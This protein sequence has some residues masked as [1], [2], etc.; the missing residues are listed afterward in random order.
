MKD[1]ETPFLRAEFVVRLREE[2][3]EVGDCWR[4]I[5]KLQGSSPSSWNCGKGAPTAVASITLS[6][7]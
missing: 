6:F 3:L 7:G 2:V 4:I 1:R 5:F